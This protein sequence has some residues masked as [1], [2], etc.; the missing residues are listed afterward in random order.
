VNNAPTIDGSRFDNFEGFR[1]EVSRVLKI[2]PRWNGNLDALADLVWD[3][4]KIIWVNSERSREQLGHDETARW[5]E[6]RL[7]KVHA[8][9]RKV[10]E[11]RVS[12]SK[13]GEGET[14][15]DNITQLIRDAGV[16]LEL[17]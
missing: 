4:P 7:G 9:N 6:S 2:E 3:F 14:L 10:W 17:S 15:F 13:R 12:A 5:L 1:D 8:A 11:L 16:E